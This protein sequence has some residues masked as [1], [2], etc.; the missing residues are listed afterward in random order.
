LLFPIDTVKVILQTASADDA[1]GFVATVAQ[2]MREKGVAG[3]YKGLG[4][5]VFKESVHSLNYWCWHE[6]IFRFFS[7]GDD[8]KTSTARRLLLN[9]IIKQ[10]NWLCT[11]PFEVVASVNQV[12]PDSSGFLGTVVKLYKLGGVG[13]FYR[14]LSI[15][16]VLAINPAMTNTLITM[17]LRLATMLKMW[18]GEDR[19]TAREHTPALVGLAT[20]VAKFIATLATYPMIRAKVLQ[21]TTIAATS[22][23]PVEIWRGIVRHE[24]MAGLWRGVLA[25]SYKTVLWNALMMAVK[26]KLEPPK[27]MTPPMTPPPEEQARSVFMGRDVLELDAA[28]EKLDEVLKHIRRDGTSER[29]AK[30]ERHMQHT[31]EEISEIKYLLQQF[32]KAGLR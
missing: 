14:G 23:S 2:V 22:Q 27:P 18:M 19:E 11:V 4:T 8:S 30:L 31:T 3:F 25:M 29:I 9:L 17:F 7:K 12:S 16:M 13:Y 26:S 32:V 10:L 20:G 28:A 6:T 24:G 5:S 21:Q 1:R 15:S